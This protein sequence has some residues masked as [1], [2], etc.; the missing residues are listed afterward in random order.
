MPDVAEIVAKVFERA[1]EDGTYREKLLAD[2]HAA[3]EEVAGQP[4]PAS[5]NVV[6]HENTT[7]TLHFTLPYRRRS[8]ASQGQHSLGGQYTHYPRALRFLLGRLGINVLAQKIHESVKRKV[9]IV[10]E[11]RCETTLSP[12]KRPSHARR[13]HTTVCS[14]QG[15]VR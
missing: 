8:R 4:I 1:A 15:P 11:S 7:T 10:V 12:R 13:Y 9:S 6:V 5:I 3:I 14:L 2:T